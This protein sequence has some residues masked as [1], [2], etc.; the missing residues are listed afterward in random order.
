MGFIVVDVGGQDKIFCSL[1][2]EMDIGYWIIFV[3]IVIV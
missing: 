1:K 3:D 2:W